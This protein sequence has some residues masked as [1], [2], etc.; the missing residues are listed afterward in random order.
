[1]SKTHLKFAI[2]VVIAVLIAWKLTV[3]SQ[4]NGELH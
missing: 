2:V 4:R 3:G 1:M